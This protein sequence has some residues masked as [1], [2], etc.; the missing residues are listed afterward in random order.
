MYMC[1]YIYI[2]THTYVHTH[3]RIRV[4]DPQ[5]ARDPVSS[6][7]LNSKKKHNLR[8]SVPISKYIDSCDRPWWIQH[9]SQE[10]YACRNSKAQG[11]EEQIRV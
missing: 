5:T 1:I 9:L 4:V 8:V 10:M 7:K 3:N 11:L 6:H 2:Y